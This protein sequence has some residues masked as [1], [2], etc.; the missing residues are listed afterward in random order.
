MSVPE[1]AVSYLEIVTPEVEAAAEFYA[2]AYGWAFDPPV[3]ELGG[4]RAATLPDGVVCGIRAPMSEQETPIVRTYLRV[5][6]IDAA[7]KRAAELGAMI[8]LEP[9]EIPGRGRVAIYFIGGVQQG[10]WEV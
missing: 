2:A 6:D 5:A 9:M 4:A 10:L 3:P 1:H 7:V 8:A